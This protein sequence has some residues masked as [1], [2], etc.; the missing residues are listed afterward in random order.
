MSSCT[1]INWVQEEARGQISYYII[2]VGSNGLRP[3]L[4]S[5]HYVG[6]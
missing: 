3:G 2:Q 6:P 1:E 5:T 4:K